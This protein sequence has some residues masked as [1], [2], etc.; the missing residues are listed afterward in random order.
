MGS[1]KG[2]KRTVKIKEEIE[3]RYNLNIIYELFYSGISVFSKANYL[4]L[5]YK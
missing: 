3:K 1:G 2:N 5:A 4:E